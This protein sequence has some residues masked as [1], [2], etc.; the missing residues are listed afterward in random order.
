MLKLPPTTPA[1]RPATPIGLRP[2][3]DSCSMSFDST[4]LRS[5]ESVCS[6]VCSA[7]TVTFSLIAPVVSEKSRVSE[8]AASSWT[9]SLHGLLEAL[10]LRR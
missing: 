7:V 9:P 6:S 4:V 1:F 5:A 10:Q 3:N 2:E 8:P